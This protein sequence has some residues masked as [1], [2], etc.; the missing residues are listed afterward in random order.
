M[1]IS[2]L[3]AVRLGRRLILLAFFFVLAVRFFLLANRNISLDGV[4]VRCKSFTLEKDHHL[5]FHW[6]G[7]GLVVFC[8]ASLTHCPGVSS[9]SYLQPGDYDVVHPQ[10][11]FQ[12]VLRGLHLLHQVKNWFLLLTD[13]RNF[14]SD[15]FISSTSS[16]I[17][18]LFDPFRATTYGVKI[19]LL[20]SW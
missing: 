20:L 10:V 8:V 1:Y 3:L 5:S 12:D 18:F 4:L 14:L 16:A 11:L 7:I 13:G 2:F 19:I 17:R 15:L 6:V 9:G